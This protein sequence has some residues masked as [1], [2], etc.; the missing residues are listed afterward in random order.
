MNIADKFAGK[1]AKCPKCGNPIQIPALEATQD[2]LF[3]DDLELSA[4]TPAARQTPTKG[5]GSN[6]RDPRGHL[7]DLLDEAGV[8]EVETG[9]TC[10][11]CGE[12]VQEG[13]L[14][15]VNCGLNFQ[16]GERV[17]SQVSAD[18]TSGRRQ[19]SETDKI[20][21]KA[22]AEIEE[23]P[24]SQEG[25]GYGDGPESFFLAAGALL[26]GALIVTAV[27]GVVFLFD[28]LTEN[29]GATVMVMIVISIV[30]S[31]IGQIWIT[32]AAFRES[33]GQGLAVLILAGLYIPVFGFMRAR[34]LWVPTMC[35]LMGQ[36][37]AVTAAINYMTAGPGS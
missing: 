17:Y 15:C 36:A 23:N 33:V 31:L 7:D 11:A 25:E 16:T 35:W 6:A 20:M 21:A 34:E 30:F 32:V 19:M 14:I 22:E 24:I 18:P 12:G 5:W 10:P 8:K 28:R 29:S 37:A 26:I 13:A 27:V 2:S 9:P 4:E 3:G 1:R